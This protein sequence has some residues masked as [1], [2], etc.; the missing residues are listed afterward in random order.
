MKVAATEVLEN[1]IKA[2]HF[3]KEACTTAQFR[4]LFLMVYLDIQ[5]YNEIFLSLL[6]GIIEV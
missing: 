5:S 2:N 1:L 4:T 3:E 6:I